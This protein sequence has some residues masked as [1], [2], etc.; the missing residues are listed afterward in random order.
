MT[1]YKSVK[2]FRGTAVTELADDVEAE[3]HRVE[4]ASKKTVSGN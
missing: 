1:V 3:E 4:T 2:R